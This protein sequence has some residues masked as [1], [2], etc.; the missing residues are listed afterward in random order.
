MLFHVGV[1]K[2]EVPYEVHQIVLRRRERP[3]RPNGGPEVVEFVYGHSVGLVRS[4]EVG[5]LL[6]QES[7][8]NS[9]GVVET[10]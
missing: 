3:Q 9:V 10:V 4:A 8:Q 5:E 1:R 2:H 6:V 7:F